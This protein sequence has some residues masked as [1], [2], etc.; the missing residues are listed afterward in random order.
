MNEILF[1]STTQSELGDYTTVNS[2][3]GTIESDFEIQKTDCIKT[4]KVISGPEEANNN[5][6]RYATLQWYSGIFISDLKITN[7]D[8]ITKKTKNK[9]KTKTKKNKRKNMGTTLNQTLAS[10]IPTGSQK[11]DAKS[12]FVIT[13]TDWIKGQPS[14]DLKILTYARSDLGATRHLV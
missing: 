10:Y 7:T 3:L 4:G 8:T 6:N 13:H 5:S 2:D 11:E 9:T 12:D 14:F 1:M